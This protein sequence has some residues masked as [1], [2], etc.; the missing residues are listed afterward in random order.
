MNNRVCSV[1]LKIRPEEH[2]VDSRNPS[3]LLKMCDICRAR[4]RERARK[5]RAAHPG[6]GK[7]RS[8]ALAEQHREA[9][10]KWYAAHADEHKAK[11]RE[12]YAAHSEQAIDGMRKRRAADPEKYRE[13]ARRSAQR[14]RAKKATKGR[15]A[16]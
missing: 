12:Y 13:I 10:R 6:Y 16:A 1:C 8:P 7:N 4:F 9:C 5:F 2:F 15:E 14:Q 3:R 11:G